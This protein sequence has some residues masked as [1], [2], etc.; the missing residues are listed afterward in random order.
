MKRLFCLVVSALFTG[1][2]IMFIQPNQKASALSGN[3][4]NPGRIIDDSVFFNK[5][6]LSLAQIQSFLDSKVDDCDTN[7]DKPYYSTGMTRKQWAAANGK[8]APPYTCL[9]DGSFSVSGKPA[10][11]YCT[12]S[13]SSGTRT[14]AQIIREVGK[15]CNISQKV[16]IVLLQKEQS[17]ITD[18]WPW[19][20]QYEK[21]TGFSCPDTAP[22]DPEFAGFFNQLYY[23]A[24]QYQRYAK[25]SEVFRYRANR[26]N[27]IQYS[28]NGACGSS[29][30]FIENQATAGLYNYTPYQ[31]NAAA[32]GNLY[33]T[34][35]SCSAY[36]NRNFW[37]MFNDWFGETIVNISFA[38][39]DGTLIRF[40]N[41]P[42]VFLVGSG[43][44]RSLSSLYVFL[45]QGYK[46]DN[47]KIATLGDEDLV[48]G[49]AISD[50]REGTLLRGNG[51]STVYMT[52]ATDSGDQKRSVGSFKNF[53]RLGLSF[54]DV[55]V[56][57]TS[58]IDALPTGTPL[59]ESDTTHPDGSLIRNEDSNEVFLVE[60]QTLRSTASLP[61]FLSY[62][63]NFGRVDT[64]FSGDDSLPSGPDLTY[65]EGA[66][67][68]G[69]SETIYI[70]N[71]SYGA[72]QKRSLGSIEI[73][74]GL[75]YQFDEVIRTKD[76]LLPTAN[77]SVVGT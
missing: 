42:E 11:A 20:V 36:G 40:P 73:F 59:S 37:R 33:G 44:R 38:H 70:T 65:R 15:A 31:P 34:G 60:D 1:S 76:S 56:V 5:E 32:L 47:V 57:P 75:G 58:V 13:V 21:A 19:P 39:P 9:K 43:Q 25:Q 51:Q 55:L 50:Y 16:L 66:L 29:T 53:Q 24:R 3:D 6:G 2:M 46:H 23:A 22:C 26:N 74:E 45:S 10:D 68:K 49:S 77:G 52:D 18:D 71:M 4:F 67:L 72:I 69:N 8:P 17:L 63:Y 28:P 12:G 61:I 35:D 7:G 41:D 64:F 14:A 30:V 48:E 27:D 62:A 54:K